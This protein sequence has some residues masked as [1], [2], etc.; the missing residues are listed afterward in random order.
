[1][2]QEEVRFTRHGL[3]FGWLEKLSTHKNIHTVLSAFYAINIHGT[4]DD[5]YLGTFDYYRVVVAS[6]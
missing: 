4:E 1:M 5:L 6:K 2:S 3:L